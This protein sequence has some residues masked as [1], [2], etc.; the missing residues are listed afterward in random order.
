MAH[1]RLRLLA[2]GRL[3]KRMTVRGMRRPPLERVGVPEKP[4]EFL[5]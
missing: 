1:C 4:V 5:P 3:L 2:H